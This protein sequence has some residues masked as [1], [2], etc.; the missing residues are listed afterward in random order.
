MQLQGL[1][2]KALLE[3]IGDG[4]RGVSV[5]DLYLE[6][7]KLEVKRGALDTR[8]WVWYDREVAYPTDPVRMPS[9]NCWL[10]L[11]GV[12]VKYRNNADLIDTS[13]QWM[14]TIEGVKWQHFSNLVVLQL[15][16]SG[17]EV[18]DLRGLRCLRSLELNWDNSN[19]SY[20]GRTKLVG[21]GEL[22]NLGWL[23]LSNIHYAPSFEEIGC[24]TS[25][26][27]LRLDVIVITIVR[28][29][30]FHHQI[31]ASASI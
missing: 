9:S 11:E 19:G 14:G 21:L 4:F 27:V 17:H 30:R 29:G 16:I 8:L 13:V 31:L 20:N 18:L 2:A 15:F 7:A 12:P 25:L 1:K 6:F 28:E 26:E 3:D 22:R 5:H 23:D 24:L 10:K